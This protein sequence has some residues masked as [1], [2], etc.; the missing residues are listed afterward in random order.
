MICVSL[1]VSGPTDAGP[2]RPGYDILSVP[3]LSEGLVKSI[4]YKSQIYNKQC[5]YLK[6]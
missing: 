3:T 5:M 1:S 6:F 2:F 4:S